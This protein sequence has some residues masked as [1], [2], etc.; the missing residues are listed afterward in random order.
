MRIYARLGILWWLWGITARE[1][2]RKELPFIQSESFFFRRCSIFLIR[3][4]LVKPSHEGVDAP[5]HRT[6]RNTQCGAKSILN[7]SG[8]R[9]LRRIQQQTPT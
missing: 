2:A 7:L 6:V 4:F 9:P 1:A 3:F 8:S 5:R